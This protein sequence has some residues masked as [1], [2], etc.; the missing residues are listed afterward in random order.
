MF[1]PYH[2]WLGIP[3]DQRPPTHYQLLGIAVDETDTEVIQEA[4]LRQTSHVRLYQTGP[5]AAQA[6]TIL[7][8]IGQARAVLLN[9]EK[10]KQYDASLAPP[11]AETPPGEGEA[12]LEVEAS[13][14]RQAGSPYP[15]AGEPASVVAEMVLDDQ[16]APRWPR[17]R[18]SGDVL[19]PALGFAALVLLGAALAFGMGLARPSPPQERSREPAQKDP[20]PSAKE[21]VKPIPPPP[22]RDTGLTFEGHEAAVRALAVT[23]DGSLLSAG[24]SYTAGTEGEPLG[25]VLRR[26]DLR[27]GKV[28][29]LFAGHQ[30]PI[31][32]LAVSAD[33]QQ[34]LTGSGGSEW[35]DGIAVPNDCVIRLWDVSTGQERLT[36][37]EH[38]APVRGVAFLPYG[39]RVVSLSSDGV[40]LLWDLRGRPLPR[41]LTRKPSPAGCLAASPGG[42]FVLVG[43]R[44]G[45]LRLWDLRSEQEVERFPPT[46]AP[47]HA[48][49]F[50][51]NTRHVAT[52]SGRLV[53]QDNQPVA[54]GCLVRVWDLES[55]K[56]LHELAG[57]TRPVRGVAWTR[58]GRWV[59]S[60]ALDG[61]VRLWEAR[62]GKLIH[63]FEAGSG[64]TCVALTSS[65]LIAGTLTGVIRVWDLDSALTAGREEP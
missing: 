33:G 63:P 40:L 28:L 57:H 2:R 52:G 31:H 58:D 43:G 30:T 9:P 19:V 23:A 11:P 65:R 36:F 64:V 39:Q 54:E 56:L 7:N 37:S 35:R 50:A 62:T 4:A 32:C 13:A 59:A 24:G 17:P 12:R 6:T 20:N 3:R 16:P 48:V 8:E 26:W 5:Y 21:P 22:R 10:R 44:E 47:I 46:D 41:S 51:P 27:S 45:Q 14:K 38:D 55:G 61:T 60:G 34:V 25:C 29:D 1:D 53:Y 15:P 42:R 18:S 49:A